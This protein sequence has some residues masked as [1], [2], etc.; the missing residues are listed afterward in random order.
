MLNR[1][2]FVAITAAAAVVSAVP[3][4]AKARPELGTPFYVA[5]WVEEEASCDDFVSTAFRRV[6]KDLGIRLGRPTREA[7]HF[8]E[9]MQMH[10]N[11]VYHWLITWSAEVIG[12][13]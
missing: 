6:E 2:N 3:L 4:S 1:R 12:Y 10:S 11:R 9:G 5:D 13:A 8:P 7:V